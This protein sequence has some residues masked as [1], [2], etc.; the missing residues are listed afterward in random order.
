V[1]KA[2]LKTEATK[3][4]VASFIAK[5]DDARR[6]DCKAIDA[7]FRR[8]TG[9]KGKM[10]GTSI[11]G[12][13]SQTLTY[14]SGRSLDWMLTGWSPRKA[15]L[16]LYLQGGLAAKPELVKKLGTCTT[17]KGCLYIKRLADIDPSVLEELVRA[18][19]S[20]KKARRA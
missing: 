1:K 18:S 10:W 2:K 16:T 6:A 20:K 13:G 9:E 5:Q 7:M 12:Y 17:G 15:N 19:V 4:S 11:I 14:P 3:A 8:V